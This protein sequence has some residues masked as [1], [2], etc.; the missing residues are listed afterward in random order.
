MKTK[1][2]AAAGA[3]GFLTILTFWTATVATELFG[4]PLLH[5]PLIFDVCLAGWRDG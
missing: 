1:L 2:H 4:G 5:Q 3:I